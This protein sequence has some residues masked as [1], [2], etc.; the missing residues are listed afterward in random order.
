M[1]LGKNRGFNQFVAS[2]NRENIF[3]DVI[4]KAGTSKKTVKGIKL[5]RADELTLDFVT[6]H[7]R[8]SGIIYCF[9]RKKVDELSNLLT[10]AGFS[11]LP[12]H[13]GLSDQVRSKN[14]AAFVQDDV[15][16]IVATLAFGMGINKPNVRYVIHY[17]LPKSIE[18]YYQ[19]IGRA[20][21]DG[22]PATALLLYSYGDT[23]KI[24]FFSII[25]HEFRFVKRHNS[26]IIINMDK[27]LI[28]NHFFN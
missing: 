5:S 27:F 25:Y 16:I 8:E 3:L 4:S 14:Q 19:E 22:L 15:K 10:V 7:S 21:R 2:F 11:V 23:K 1:Q 26:H 28:D 12:Y 13:A 18:Q 17:D 20:G 6:S 9:S 24:S